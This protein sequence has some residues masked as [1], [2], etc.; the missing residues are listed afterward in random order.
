MQRTW[1]GTTA[2]VLTLI[3]G[4]IGIAGGIAITV[5]LNF[6]SG[7]LTFGALLAPIG[8][9]LIV[10][11]IIALI[12]AIFMFRRKSWGFCLAGAICAMFPVL[13]LGI[14]AIILLAL[15]K[16]EFE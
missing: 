5:G 4:I 14:I 10:L 6:I 15:A 11:G 8:P 13:P 16:K 1:K 12:G 2:G 9:I 7:F 3:G